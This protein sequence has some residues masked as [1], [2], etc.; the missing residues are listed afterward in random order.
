[1][2]RSIPNSDLRRTPY[3]RVHMQGGAWFRVRRKEDKRDYRGG[4]YSAIVSEVLDQC[5]HHDRFDVR[6]R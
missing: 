1:M 6:D 4:V 3:I 5:P 2:D